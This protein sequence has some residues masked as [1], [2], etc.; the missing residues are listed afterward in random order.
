MS[1]HDDAKAAIV[2]SGAILDRRA[3]VVLEAP[4]LI[5]QG[6]MRYERFELSINRGDESAL[7][8]RRD[9]LRASRVAAL[10]PVDLERGQLVLI[11]QFRLAAHLATGRGEMVE[12]VAGRIEPGEAAAA[13][14]RRECME[15]IGVVPG[16][17]VELYS[18]LPTPGLTD[19]I[20]TFFLGFVDAAQ[21]PARAGAAEEAED[22]RPFVVSIDDAVTVLEQGRV[23]NGLLVTALQW[24]ALHHGRLREYFDRAGEV[25]QAAT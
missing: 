16:R 2:G 22:T 15:E 23:A 14:A 3:D 7:L 21:V 20:V 17:L 11:R 9:V 24:L 1:D 25:D 18:V 8:Q 6:Y 4:S 5:G 10:L 19:E 13:A 12:I